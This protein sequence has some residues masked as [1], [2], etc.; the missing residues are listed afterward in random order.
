MMTGS[1]RFRDAAAALVIAVLA[2]L[3]VLTPPFERLRGLSIDV[4][5][6][7]RWRLAGSMHQPQSSPTVVVALDEET[8]RTPPF[9]G[10]P[11]ITWTREIGQ[12]LTAVLDGGAKVVG[13]DIVFPTSIEQSEIPFGD[14]TLGARLRGFDRDFLRAL[15]LG[16]HAGKVVLGEAQHREYPILPAPGQRIAVGQNDNIRSLNVYSDP[17]DVVRRI[18]LSVT[19]DG[20]A[21]PPMAVELA[22]RALGATP[23]TLSG[24]PFHSQVPNTLALNFDGGADTI[25]TFSLAD[26]RACSE[27]GDR[28]FFRRNFDGKV[29]L[30]ATVLDV[31]DRQVTSKRFATAPEN[32]FGPR[33]ALPRPP[34][35]TVFARDSTPGVYTHATAVNNL[36]QGDA[37]IEFGQIG[38]GLISFALA[39][40]AAAAVLT[41]PL[42]AAVLAGLLSGATWTAGAVLVFSHSPLLL[43]LIEPLLAGLVSFGV[44]TGYRF[45]VADKDRRFLRKSF[46]LYLAPAVVEKMVAANKPPAL[47][48]E[49]RDVTVFFSDLAGFS[50]ISEALAPPDLVKFIN[51]Y[52]SAM[53]DII[54]EHGG[55][56]DKYIGDAIVAVFGAPL[57]DPNHAENAVRAAL[58]CRDRLH[59]LNT[60]PTEWQRFSLRQR[61][62]LNSGDAL[63]GN[64]GSRH[65]FNYTVMGDTVNVASRLEGANKYF[66]TSIMA[67][68]STVARV[69][70][71]AWRELDSIRVQ[72]RDEP[73]SVY[74]P[75]APHG[76]ETPEQKAWSS[77][78]GHALACW[79]ARDFAGAAAALSPI[80]AADPPAAILLQRAK[81]FLAHPPAADWAAINALEG[82]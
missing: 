60:D 9:A 80:A 71:F 23:A 48:G 46:A 64:I 28:E 41:L 19:V 56:V 31:E 16:A 29:V 74:E 14:G 15:A 7:L 4:L 76:E 72:G 21:E 54:Q 45:L 26:L 52:L 51:E 35:S 5:T 11:A 82:K 50:S 1:A 25:P 3:L 49:T 70:R 34:P 47:G 78:Y 53:T 57:D 43:P 55:F 65:R 62:G 24:S 27:K 13:F 61:I 12:V 17:D 44:M 68:K 67:A 8:Y 36:L 42:I 20:K 39:A 33:C 63:V 58:R 77:A 69:A 30:I 18:P 75:L 66:G 6:A 32:A 81:K 73:I 10:T 40:L 59:S 38:R 2:G 37:L 79:R 22:A